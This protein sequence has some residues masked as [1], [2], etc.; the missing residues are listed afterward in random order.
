MKS[1]T[2]FFYA[3]IS[4]KGMNRQPDGTYKVLPADIMESAT[5][6]KWEQKNG[7]PWAVVFPPNVY[8]WAIA[9]CKD[10]VPCTQIETAL[11]ELLQ[12]A[13]KEEA[14]KPKTERLPFAVLWLGVCGNIANTLGHFVL[15]M[16]DEPILDGASLNQFMNI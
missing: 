7:T 11:V 13:G 16:T 12:A 1:G 15:N 3:F 6:T 4:T 2:K 10:D 8:L 9:K 14:L 5:I